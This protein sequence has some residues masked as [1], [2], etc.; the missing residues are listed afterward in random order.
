MKIAEGNELLLIRYGELGLKGKN[1]SQFIKRLAQNA[2]AQLRGVPGTQ[3]HSSWGR[4][5]VETADAPLAIARLKQVFG[6]Y[7]LSPVISVE[8]DIDQIADAA[9]KVLKKALPN[10]GTFKVESRRADKTFP[11]TSPELSRTVAGRLFARLGDD[12]DAD[13]R[14]P[15]QMLNIEIRAE[16]AFV[17]CETIPCAGGLPVG[18]SG[19]A[20]V[21]LSGG[22]DS[23]V[24][25]W[26]AMRRGVVV[27]AIHFHSFPFTSEQSKDKVVTLGKMLAQWHGAPIRLHVVHFTE[28][29]R[30]IYANCSEEYGITIMRRMMFRIA[31]RIAKQRRAMAIYTGESVGQVASQTLESIDTI[32]AVVDMPVL[33]P[34]VAMDKEWIIKYAQEIGTF[35]TSIL[36]FEDCCTVFLPKYPKIHPKREEAEELEKNLDIEALITEALEKTEVMLLK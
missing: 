16:G 26:M 32:N 21:L 4:L 6:I 28:I 15:Q 20:V 11:I 12:Y 31:E 7:S 34:L 25:T 10:G 36:P 18:C 3:V 35:E 17:F 9:Y 14:N 5:W 8:K 13:M 27:E 24:A 33:R 29:Q 22:I 30:A 19:K 1:K 23:P 2:R